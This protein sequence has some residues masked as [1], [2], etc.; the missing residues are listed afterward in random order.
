MVV[1]VWITAVKSVFFWRFKPPWFP[2]RFPHGSQVQVFQVA[3]L[4][5]REK[6]DQDLRFKFHCS[7][8][9]VVSH[10]NLDSHQKSGDVL[11]YLPSN[12]EMWPWKIEVWSLIP[13]VYGIFWSFASSAMV[14]WLGHMGQGQNLVLFRISHSFWV[15]LEPYH[16]D[17]PWKP[18]TIEAHTVQ[19]SMHIHALK[20]TSAV[21]PCKSQ[22]KIGVW[23]YIPVQ[24]ISSM[25]IPLSYHNPGKSPM[26]FPWC[27]WL[28]RACPRRW[29]ESTFN[30][31]SRHFSWIAL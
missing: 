20:E 30:V 16:G 4:Q 10:K 23:F 18:A 25:F 8:G 13:L 15:I 22:L 19:M 28:S 12:M 6:H 9:D 5:E 29:K 27:P 14:W 21:K 24:F 31:S 3:E 26:I 2:P 17:G 11:I 1:M 7:T